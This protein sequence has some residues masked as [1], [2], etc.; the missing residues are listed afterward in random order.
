M[1][2]ICVLSNGFSLT[3]E[4]KVSNTVFRIFPS[5]TR[6]VLVRALGPLSVVCEAVQL[7]LGFVFAKWMVRIV[8]TWFER[9]RYSLSLFQ[10]S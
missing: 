9:L 8:H 2:E 1:A 3:C 4:E 6:A 10:M 5:E 7:F